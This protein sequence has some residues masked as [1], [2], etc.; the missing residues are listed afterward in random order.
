MT[1][2]CDS[3]S[4]TVGKYRETDAYADEEESFFQESLVHSRVLLQRDQFRGYTLEEGRRFLYEEA[5]EVRL[6]PGRA[7]DV[8]NDWEHQLF[9]DYCCGHARSLYRQSENLQTTEEKWL[10]RYITA[11]SVYA[12]GLYA[13]TLSNDVVRQ[14]ISAFYEGEEPAPDDDAADYYSEAYLKDLMGTAYF[15]DS[16]YSM[17]PM[18]IDMQ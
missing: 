9:L 12:Y 4:Q 14:N 16:I 15:S 18:S 13:R 1:S 7:L 17:P 6:F 5:D 3:W 10:W 8:Q 2:L 11:C